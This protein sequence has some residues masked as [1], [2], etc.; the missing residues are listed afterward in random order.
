ML[1]YSKEQSELYRK[2]YEEMSKHKMPESNEEGIQRYL[3]RLS[4]IRVL[5]IFVF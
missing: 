1:Q 4:L 5:V 3:A 2:M